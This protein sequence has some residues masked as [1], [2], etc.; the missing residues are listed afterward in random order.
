[1]QLHSSQPGRKLQQ[2]R[3]TRGVWLVSG[4]AV[5]RCRAAIARGAQITPLPA[6]CR[7]AAA[8]PRHARTC[9][10]AVVENRAKE[11]GLAC[12]DLHSMKLTLCQFIEASRSYTG[13]LHLLEQLDPSELVVVASAH[14][15]FA[16]S[17]ASDTQLGGPRLLRSGPLRP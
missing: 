15:A 1:M 11:V 14:Q 7:P 13:A 3:T 5:Q 2:L 12:L 6:S 16:A 10:A 4:H 17:G 9:L 8:A